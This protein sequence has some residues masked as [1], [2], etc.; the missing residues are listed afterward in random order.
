MKEE[1]VFMRCRADLMREVCPDDIAADLLSRKV[2]TD[3]EKAEVD[4]V[5]TVT[6]KRGRMEKLLTAVQKATQIHN[7]NF[8]IFMEVLEEQDKYIV[9]VERMRTSLKDRGMEA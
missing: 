5:A 9:I 6:S 3:W 7:S 8:H 1:Q 4:I 2:I